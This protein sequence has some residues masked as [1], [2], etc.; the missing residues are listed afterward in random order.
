M[1]PAS[2]RGIIVR[3]GSQ[4]LRASRRSRLPA[5]RRL[6]EVCDLNYR[7]RGSRARRAVLPRA[8]EPDPSLLRELRLGTGSGARYLDQALG[9]DRIEQLDSSQQHSSSA[10]A[11]WLRS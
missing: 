10:G 7:S 6:L 1:T 4:H 2:I 8:L 9:F 11:V 5:L 3:E